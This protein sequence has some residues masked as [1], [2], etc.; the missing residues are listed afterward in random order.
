M[1]VK[2]V[3]PVVVLRKK[4]AG[5]RSLM[6]YRKGRSLSG[7]HWFNEGSASLIPWQSVLEKQAT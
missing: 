4:N 5:E 7:I 6:K 3:K 2:N 1:V